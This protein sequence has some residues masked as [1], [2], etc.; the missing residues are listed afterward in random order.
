MT[1][2][3]TAAIEN[4]RAEVE[5]MK[6]A[7]SESMMFDMARRTR[8]APLSL[9]GAIKGNYTGIIAEFKRK[10]P[11]KGNLNPLADAYEVT[12]GYQTLGA[13][14]I[15]VMTDTRFY[16]GSLSDLAMASK[17]VTIPILRMDIIIDKYQILE[18]YVYGADAVLLTASILTTD[19]IE[20]MMVVAHRFGMEVM[21]DINTAD[22]IKKITASTDIIGV[23][24]RDYKT[25]AT[26]I[27]ASYNM[28]P[29]LPKEIDKVALSGI[30]SHQD[31]HR[32]RAIGYSGFLIGETFMKKNNPAEAMY[33][34]INPPHMG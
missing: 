21:L 32:L 6:L 9:S 24:N 22:D 7:I 10:S 17:A 31:I 23:N 8:R 12:K 30:C 11:L 16:G 25:F 33:N 29:K 4:K 5:A 15:A 28:M 3:L 26:D 13:S 2:F 34:F 27:D 1:N 19:E 18:S 20:A 14:A